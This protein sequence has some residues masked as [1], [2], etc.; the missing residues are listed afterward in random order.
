VQDD[1][2]G[3]ARVEVERWAAL[4]KSGRALGLGVVVLQLALL[5]LTLELVLR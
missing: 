2:H 3:R 4:L 5:V 1:G